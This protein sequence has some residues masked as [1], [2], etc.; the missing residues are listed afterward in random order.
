MIRGLNS[1]RGRLWAALGL[2]SVAVLSVSA[3][4]WIALQRVDAGLQDLH[5]ETLSQVAQALDLSKRSSDLATSAP[6]L[7]NQRSN[8][9]IEQEGAKLVDVLDRVRTDWP[10][11]QFSDNA[12][13]GPA[14]SPILDSMTAAVTDLVAASSTL[15]AVQARIRNRTANLG[16]LRTTASAAIASNN[17]DDRTRLIWWSLQS[18]TAD[19][20]NAAYARNLIGV[21]EEQRHYLH[22]KQ[23]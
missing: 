15:D 23:A 12:N 20:L 19:A 4:S 5:R 16:M 14:V 10:Q 3:V 13:D 9:L 7:L 17:S 8:F 18:M 2:L 22:E 21:G 11:A 6:Y 1:V